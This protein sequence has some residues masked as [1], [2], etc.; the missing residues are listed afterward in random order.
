[1]ELEKQDRLSSTDLLP[2]ATFNE[3]AGQYDSARPTY[4]KQVFEEIT[5]LTG[6]KESS[7][8]LEI[9]SGT[10]HATVGF[11]HRGL[12]IHCV[13]L[14]ANMV[15]IA[16]QKLADFPSVTFEVADFDHWETKK[17]FDLAYCVSAFHWLNPAT[18]EQRIAALLQPRGW[19]AVWR[20]RHVRDSAS[21]DFL[22]ALQEVYRREAPELEKKLTILPKTTEVAEHE[23][24]PLTS[25]LFAEQPPRI[26]P[27]QSVYTGAEYVQ[28]LDTHSDHRLLSDDRRKRL[29]DGIVGLIDTRYGGSVTKNYATI[30]Q[31][32]QLQN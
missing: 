15:A 18:R 2:R 10:G 7:A 1:M 22:D 5:S 32:A 24:Y 12:S 9:G 4:P 31:L 8:L 14:G 21:N 25:G 11:A 29:F 6:L 3:V 30:L 19:L 20:H 17:K 27:C 28:M 26:Y 16:A 13:E 23:R